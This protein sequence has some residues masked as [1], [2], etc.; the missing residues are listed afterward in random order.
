MDEG[1]SSFDVVSPHVVTLPAKPCQEPVMVLSTMATARLLELLLLLQARRAAP[2]SEFAAALEVSVRTVYRDIAAL[3]EA[4]VP[5]YTETGRSGG[6]RLLETFDAAWTGTLG[7]DDARALVLA[8]VPA[9][10]S[11]VGLVPDAAQTRLVS[12]LAG[13]AGRAVSEVRNR[14]LVE[15]EPWWGAQPLSPT[16]LH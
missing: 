15:T 11:S 3:V 2:A 8:G 5:I 12:A 1:Q 4:G 6:V 14:L 16:C 9:V 13:S 7:S 10:A